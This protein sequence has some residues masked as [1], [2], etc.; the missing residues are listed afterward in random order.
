MILIGQYDSPFVR[1]VGIA[2]TLYGMVFDHQPWSAFGDGEKIARYSPLRRV[3][4]LVLDDSVAISDSWAIIDTLDQMVGPD[5][6]LIA[7]S[8][9]D[10]REAMRIIALA[11]GAADKSVALVYERVLRNEALG[12]WV[13]RCRSQVSGALDALE[14]ARSQSAASWLF[15]DGISHAD[16]L[17]ATYL[18]FAREALPEVFDLATRPA[19]AA[20]SERAEGL[21]VFQ[22]I[23]QPFVINPPT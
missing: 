4:T 8:G 10:R 23:S 5:R 3:P 13:A 20:H 6:A 18:R 19:L 21:A 22:A 2:M 1:R 12:M 15:G 17:L 7:P 9:T 16:I 11:A 14:I